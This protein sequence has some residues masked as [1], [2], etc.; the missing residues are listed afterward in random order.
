[1]FLIVEHGTKK[2]RM[3][4]YITADKKWKITVMEPNGSFSYL[5]SIF[6]NN[7]RAVNIGIYRNSNTLVD[8]KLPG[9]FDKYEIRI[10]K[11]Y[12]NCGCS[13]YELYSWQD[14]STKPFWC[15]KCKI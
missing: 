5:M 10:R 14:R 13:K 2:R 9:E 6:R 4:T 12:S 15:S 11:E 8:F 3:N 7:E 1:M